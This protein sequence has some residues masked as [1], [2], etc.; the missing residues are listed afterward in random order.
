MSP[1]S[2]QIARAGEAIGRNLKPVGRVNGPAQFRA[3]SGS[4]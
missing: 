3:H 1:S 4:F 2:I